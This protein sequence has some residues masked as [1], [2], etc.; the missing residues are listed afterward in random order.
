MDS[1]IKTAPAPAPAPAPAV[2]IVNVVTPE[3]L[4]PNLEKTEFPK[5]EIAPTTP[6]SAQVDSAG[7]PFDPAIHRPRF[8]EKGSRKGKWIP[9]SLGAPKGGSARGA[10]STASKSELPPDLSAQSPKTETA[11]TGPDKYDSLG[12]VYCRTFY[13]GADTVFSGQGE[14]NPESESEHLHLKTAV[15]N[16]LRAK[17]LEDLPPGI[18]LSL[19]VFAYSVK[20]IQKPNTNEKWK[21]L[22]AYWKNRLSGWFVNKSKASP[23]LGG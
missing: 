23:I 9:L 13:A 12:E 1:Q 19:A 20:R 4:F 5:S 8:F 14:W 17:Q 2:E 15:A 21:L 10:D 11:P 3:E 7:V 16:Y 22:V 6:V 18:A